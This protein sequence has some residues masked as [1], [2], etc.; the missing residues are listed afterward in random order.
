MEKSDIE[1]EQ[2]EKLLKRIPFDDS[3]FSSVNEYKIILEDL[4]DNSKNIALSVIYPF[5]D[6]YE[7]ELPKKYLNWQI[8]ACIEL[9]NLADKGSF[10]SY[11]ENSLSWSRLTDGLSKALMNELTAKVGIPKKTTGSEENV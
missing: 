1:K 3:I 10:I 5:E 4:L 11:S 7:M 6:Y 9:Y 8:R 2:F